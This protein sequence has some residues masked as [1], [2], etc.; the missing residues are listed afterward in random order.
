MCYWTFQVYSFHTNEVP[1]ILR[2]YPFPG[3]FC[4]L[5][6]VSLDSYNSTFDSS[7]TDIVRKVNL[8]T[9]IAL[10]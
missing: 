7:N 8:L 6:T 10:F 1:D 3:F 5:K 9:E 2:W 4:L